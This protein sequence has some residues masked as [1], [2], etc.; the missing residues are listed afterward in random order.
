M[1]YPLIA[2]FFSLISFA[3]SEDDQNFIELY[4]KIQGL[5]REISQLRNQI[6]ILET[7]VA[8][9][10]DKNSNRLDEIDIK[11]FSLMSVN[12]LQKIDPENTKPDQPLDNYEQAIVLI[13]QGKLDD[14]LLALNIFVQNSEDATQI[15]LAYFWIGEIHLNKGNLTASTQNFNT[16]LGLYPAHWRAP[17]AKYKLGTIYLNEGDSDR[18]KAQ[19]LKVIEEYPESSAAKA[20][21]ET[22]S[23][24][25]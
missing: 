22:L 13:Q 18:A 4:M 11:L 17:L 8:F 19:F 23:S 1:K 14:A 25:E 21:R 9:Y 2:I 24:L 3:E 20:S 6:E 12:D 16:L 5:E 15:P 7:Q 10:Q